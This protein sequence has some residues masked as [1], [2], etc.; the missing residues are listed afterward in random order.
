[1]QPFVGALYRLSVSFWAGGVGIFTLVLTP[2]LF[3]TQPRDLAARI[4]GVLF[5]G[6]FR[7]GQ[8]CGAVA[9]VCL[10]ITRGANFAA[11]LVILL[12]MLALVSYQAF[13]IE[14][15][16]AA[17]KREIPSF[18]TTPKDNPLRRQFSRL[19]AVSATCNILVFAGGV[20]LVVLF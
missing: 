19:H 18:E 8:A 14:P 4:V 10:L 3:K 12:L 7:W 5:P 20:A 15:R 17:L 13:S 16:A 11:A 1:M 9:L 6:Y 2:T